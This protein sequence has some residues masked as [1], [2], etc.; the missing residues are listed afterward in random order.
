M[1]SLFLP[2][3]LPLSFFLIL[4]LS[5]LPPSLLPEGSSDPIALQ[6]PA[7][8]QLQENLARILS[9]KLISDKILALPSTA[10]LNVEPFRALQTLVVS[11]NN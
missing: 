2:P 10:T 11:A 1:S 5:S 9:L 8:Q 6:F 3:S 4:S 7:L